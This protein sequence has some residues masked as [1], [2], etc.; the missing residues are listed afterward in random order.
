[1]LGFR[2]NPFRKTKRLYCPPILAE[3]RSNAHSIY[4]SL[5]HPFILAA[6]AVGG[7]PITNSGITT[8]TFFIL[9]FHFP[10][11]HVDGKLPLTSVLTSNEAWSPPPPWISPRSPFDEPPTHPPAFA[12][13]YLASIPSDPATA[14]LHGGHRGFDLGDWHPAGWSA[15]F[16]GLDRRETV[17]SRISFPFGYFGLLCWGLSEI[18]I[19]SQSQSAQVFAPALKVPPG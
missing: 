17:R 10:E 19:C 15:G 5:L 13:A 14:G 4:T 12:I 18:S 7:E 3:L 11:A 16:Q 9:P 1:M 8:V 6:A 2:S